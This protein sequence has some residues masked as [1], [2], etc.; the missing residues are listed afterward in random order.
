MGICN[1]LMVSLPPSPWTF[2]QGACRH[3]CRAKKE[4]QRLQKDENW[5]KSWTI[6]G[7]WWPFKAQVQS[8]GCDRS[9]IPGIE[10]CSLVSRIMGSVDPSN[11]FSPESPLGWGGAGAGTAV[12]PFNS[13]ISFSWVEIPPD[14]EIELL[15]FYQSRNSDQKGSFSSFKDGSYFILLRT[16]IQLA[17]QKKGKRLEQGLNGNR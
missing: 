17:K 15:Q 1:L 3:W 7:R 9:W 8:C 10:T 2:L 4:L 6:K 13:P 11:S 12:L 5:I 16:S 14:L